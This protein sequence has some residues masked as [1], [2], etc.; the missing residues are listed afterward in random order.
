M[1]N[2]HM[3]AWINTPDDVRRQLGESPTQLQFLYSGDSWSSGDGFCLNGDPLEYYRRDFQNIAHLPY[4]SH[5]SYPLE[6]LLTLGQKLIDEVRPSFP[7]FLLPKAEPIRFYVADLGA[8]I[9]FD[10]RSGIVEPKQWTESECDL[11]LGSQALWFAF[12]FPWGFSTLEVSGRYKLI[13]PEVN[14]LAMYLCHLYSSDIHFKG[15]WRRLMERR[16]WSFCWSKR[17]EVLDRLL[18]KVVT[19][20]K[21]S[22]LAGLLRKRGRPTLNARA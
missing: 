14:R 20:T 17:Q 5:P 11:V 19:R 7:A 18:S 16:A 21:S 9:H 6:E 22:A 3:N 8:A 13:N 2:Q 1:E 4:R 15:L 10:I 12:K